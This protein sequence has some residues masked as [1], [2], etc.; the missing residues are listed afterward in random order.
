MTDQEENDLRQE[1]RV[2]YSIAPL[3]LPIL[4]RRKTNVLSRMRL[5][6]QAKEKDHTTLVAELSVLTDLE[7][8][9]K[10]KKQEYQVLE[11]KYVA[12]NVK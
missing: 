6:H 12:R 5:A 9:I 10:R 11:D 4:E 8:E 7:D 1:A 2:F 3:V